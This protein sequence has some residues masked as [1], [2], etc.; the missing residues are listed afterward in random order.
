MQTALAHRLSRRRRAPVPTAR[1]RSSPTPPARSAG[2]RRRPAVRCRQSDRRPQCVL[3]R[4]S[5]TVHARVRLQAHGESMVR[6]QFRRYLARCLPVLP[7]ARSGAANDSRGSRFPAPVNT[8][9]SL[10]RAI[11][12]NARFP[13]MI[14]CTNSTATCWASLACGPS[15]ITNRDA[16]AAE[17]FSH[18][19]AAFR[20]GRRFDRKERHRRG[21]AP[22]KVFLHDRRRGHGRHSILLVDNCSSSC[23]YASPSSSRNAIVRF[24][25]SSSILLMA[26][27]T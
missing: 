4:E 27:P 18:A 25:S 14:G 26:N 7:S 24:A 8:P 23:S 16:P 20:D 12:G 11:A 19:S 13:T 1:G 15:P 9:M 3:R 5:S 21:N 17:A 22:R 6:H 10:V 2:R